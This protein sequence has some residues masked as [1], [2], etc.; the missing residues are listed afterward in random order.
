[1]A[2]L[3]PLLTQSKAAGRLYPAARR[4]YRPRAK[5]IMGIALPKKDEP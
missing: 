1:M 2:A 4:P 5:A 3:Q